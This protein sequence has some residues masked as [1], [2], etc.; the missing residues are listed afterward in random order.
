MVFRSWA[1]ERGICET[2]LVTLKKDVLDI[3]YACK[4][5][6]KPL[7]RENVQI[8]MQS[9]LKQEILYL[10]QHSSKKGH[11]IILKNNNSKSGCRYYQKTSLH[12]LPI[13]I[14]AGGTSGRTSDKVSKQDHWVLPVKT[15]NSYAWSAFQTI[16]DMSLSGICMYFPVLLHWNRWGKHT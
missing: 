3:I 4:K 1:G 7:F 14:T 12:S 8:G 15:V 6:S 5:I 16:A 10:K 11:L 13:H 9:K 2:I